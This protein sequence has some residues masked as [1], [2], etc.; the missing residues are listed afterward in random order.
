MWLKSRLA[1]I[2]VKRSK[3]LS[4]KVIAA[5]GPHAKAEWNKMRSIRHAVYANLDRLW[6]LYSGSDPVCV[7]ALRRYTLLGGGAE[8]FFLL[9]KDFA[10]ASRSSL[11]FI[12]RALARI[13]RCCGRLMVRVEKDFW[14]GE[15]FVRYFGFQKV[16]EG[17]WAENEYSIFELRA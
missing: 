11:R 16:G 7:I 14:I 8:V 10:Q 2:R 15:K 17:S 13:L 6:T 12:R 1:M 4:A 5:L 3:V 9:C